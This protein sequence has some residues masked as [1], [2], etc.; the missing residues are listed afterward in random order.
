MRDIELRSL[1][2]DGEHLILVDS[3]GETYRLTIDEALRSAVRR[4]R[5][6]LEALRAESA[7][8]LRPR[9]IQGLLRAGSSVEEVAER[10]GLS[11][12]TVRRYEGP[13]LAEQAWISEQTRAL[14]IGHEVGA[15]TLGDLVLDRLAAR[16]VEAVGEWTAT[17]KAGD[18]WEVAVS[19]PAGGTTRRAAWHVDLQARTLTALD[20]ES[21]WLSETDLTGR[22]GRAN[23]FDIESTTRRGADVTVRE[24][25]EEDA[26]AAL[27][28]RL[29]QARGRRTAPAGSAEAAEPVEP[30][31][32][33]EPDRVVEHNAP[34]STP[35][36][37]D[38]ALFPVAPVLRL[39][40]RDEA[41]DQADPGADQA[42]ESP[43]PEPTGRGRQRA[44]RTS[45]PS[46]DEIVFGARQD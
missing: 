37:L 12:D 22:R 19:F 44:R 36:P 28:E 29:A 43:E 6:H 33:P 40:A 18:P 26:T 2:A 41:E 3:D 34:A 45:V 25:A 8:G 35:S 14:P 20:D 23:P 15:P 13:V 31:T 46:W 16:G 38:D 1:H 21:R 4:D 7:S 17:R 24:H 9:E 10:G 11:P 5:P 42:T 30:V 39:P 27:L 32:S